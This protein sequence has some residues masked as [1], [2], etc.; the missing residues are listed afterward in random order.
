MVRF[1]AFRCPAAVAPAG[2]GAAVAVESGAARWVRVAAGVELGCAVL[3]F[4]PVA[5]TAAGDRA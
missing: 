2:V 1:V 4:V 3:G 5:A